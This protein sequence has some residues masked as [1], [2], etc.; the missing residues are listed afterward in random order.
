MTDID[1]KL[2]TFELLKDRISKQFKSVNFEFLYPEFTAEVQEKIITSDQKEVFAL[3]FSQYSDYLEGKKELPD[4]IIADMFAV[5]P[6]K[7]AKKH[8]IPLIVNFPNFT[9]PSRKL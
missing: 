6:M 2:I 7:F 8:G 1:V 9:H 5:A 3:A 4:L